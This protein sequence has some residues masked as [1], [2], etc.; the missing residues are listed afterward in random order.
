MKDQDLDERMGFLKMERMEKVGEVGKRKRDALKILIELSR[1]TNSQVDESM[2]NLLI[3]EAWNALVP[4]G[5]QL[6]CD[7]RHSARSCLLVRS[8][9]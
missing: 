6:P 7:S 8:F 1:Q 5:I 2:G 4:S 3:S 9:R